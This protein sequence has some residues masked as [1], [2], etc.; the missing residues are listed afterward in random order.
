[1]KQSKELSIV[2]Y[3]DRAVKDRCHG[4]SSHMTCQR[5]TKCQPTHAFRL[6]GKR[7]AHH[8]DVCRDCEE[9]VLRKGKDTGMVKRINEAR[10]W[11]SL[12]TH[13]QHLPREFRPENLEQARGMIEP[14]QS[15]EQVAEPARVH[16]GWL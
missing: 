9:A 5:C 3:G 1:M 13:F 15:Q 14:A 12:Q 4:K 7:H 8:I 6:S 10:E 16:K 11:A 2:D